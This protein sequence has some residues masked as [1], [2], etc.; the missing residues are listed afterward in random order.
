MLRD[1]SSRTQEEAC[2]L[3]AEADGV[4]VAVFPATNIYHSPARYQID[5]FEQLQIF[6]TMDQ[7]HWKLMA[8]YHSHPYG[9]AELSQS[10]IEQSG[11]PETAY[12][13]WWKQDEKWL[14]RGYAIEAQRQ[15]RELEIVTLQE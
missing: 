11:Y 3:L 14:C 6:K 12:L 15:V 8:I 2:G 5:P 1:V 13:L 4:S 7:N 9:P 10:D